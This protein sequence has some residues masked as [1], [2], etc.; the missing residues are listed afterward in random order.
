[1]CLKRRSR[2]G[3]SPEFK[4]NRITLGSICN[5]LGPICNIFRY[6]DSL[7]W[8][9]LLGHVNECKFKGSFSNCG[10]NKAESF[11]L[12]T[13]KHHKTLTFAAP[14]SWCWWELRRP[15]SPG[16]TRRSPAFPVEREGQTL[17]YR[18]GRVKPTPSVCISE[19]SKVH[20]QHIEFSIHHYFW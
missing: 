14:H 20:K 8:H 5:Y 3:I 17:R 18:E 9:N 16:S 12:C 11:S 4:A 13:V 19:L 2:L 6:I 1:M 15:V 10:T 7:H